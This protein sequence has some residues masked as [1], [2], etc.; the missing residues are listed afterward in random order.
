M[1]IEVELMPRRRVPQGV[2]LSAAS[3][4]CMKTRS[5]GSNWPVA[6]VSRQDDFT[7][8]FARMS[9]VMILDA[10]AR[11]IARPTARLERMTL[12]DSRPE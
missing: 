3:N 4:A 10:W 2:P 8:R 12:R 6:T 1:S 7:A 9:R 11:N 5:K